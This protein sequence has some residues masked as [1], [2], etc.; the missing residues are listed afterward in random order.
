MLRMLVTLGAVLSLA[1]TGWADEEVI[2]VEAEAQ[3]RVV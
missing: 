1:G 3:P 2:R